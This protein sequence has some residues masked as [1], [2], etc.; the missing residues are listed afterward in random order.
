[1]LAIHFWTAGA[2][3]HLGLLAVCGVILRRWLKPAARSMVSGSGP[4][5]AGAR[6]LGATVVLAGLTTLLGPR[7]VSP[8]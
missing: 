8:P 4:W 3:F 6:F 5:L 7:S 1:M 2:V